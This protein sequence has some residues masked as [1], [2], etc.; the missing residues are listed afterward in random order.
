[1]NFTIGY[2]KRGDFTFHTSP[3]HIPKSGEIVFNIPEEE[4]ELIETV[5]IYAPEPGIKSFFEMLNEIR[6][7]N[8][9]KKEG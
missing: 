2:Y 9:E 6:G 3:I 4:K 8:A 1:M 5:Y 7:I